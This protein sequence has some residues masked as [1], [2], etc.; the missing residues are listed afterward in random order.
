MLLG[1]RKKY[2]CF[3]FTGQVFFFLISPAQEANCGEKTFY[4][5]FT[6]KRAIYNKNDYFKPR[7]FYLFTRNFYLQQRLRS[8]FFV[9]HH[10]LKRLLTFH[11]IWSFSDFSFTTLILI[12]PLFIKYSEI[13]ILQ[14]LSPNS[15]QQLSGN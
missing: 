15:K 6:K 12:I 4:L 14:K 10:Q 7:T 5:K 9:K 1:Q 3:R 11:S 2:L 13:I 8:F